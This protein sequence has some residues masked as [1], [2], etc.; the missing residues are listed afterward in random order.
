MRPFAF[1]G[2]KSIVM[3]RMSRIIDYDILYDFSCDKR[4]TRR[5]LPNR[6]ILINLEGKKENIA[7]E[8]YDICDT[9][10]VDLLWEY[11]GDVFDIHN[12]YYQSKNE[13]EISKIC[14]VLGYTLTNSYLF[15]N[16]FNRY[17][18]INKVFYR[19]NEKNG[20]YYLMCNYSEI[21]HIQNVMH[22]EIDVDGELWDVFRHT[23]LR[24]LDLKTNMP[25]IRVCFDLLRK[26]PK[27]KEE[28][29]G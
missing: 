17:I 25:F 15:N 12:K 2:E 21:Y 9:L 19:Y 4:I 8:L 27:L 6:D 24:L 10:F 18:H 1:F 7:S 23:T 16:E 14:E 20:L 26:I 11:D 13:D 3:K 22:Y 29:F 5:A 28:L